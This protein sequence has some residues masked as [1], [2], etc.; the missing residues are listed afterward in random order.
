MG[1]GS[2][3]RAG[4]E[5]NER[6]LCR[7][8]DVLDVSTERLAQR[9]PGS[10]FLHVVLRLRTERRVVGLPDS[11]LGVRRAACRRILDSEP[12]R[13]QRLSD[14]GSIIRKGNYEPRL[15]ASAPAA[16]CRFCILNTSR[17]TAPA[18]GKLGAADTEFSA[19]TVGAL[20]SANFGGVSRI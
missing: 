14:E 15:Y 7:A 17:A 13:T 9:R 4:G 10:F 5:K 19:H 11:N 1:C 3:H 6:T 2:A 12:A 16:L 20:F 18:H 8:A